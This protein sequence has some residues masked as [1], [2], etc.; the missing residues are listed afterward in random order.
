M[1][2]FASVLLLQA[3]TAQVAAPTT[4]EDVL[5][6]DT[7]AKL[8][9]IAVIFHEK[10]GIVNEAI[11]AAYNKHITKLQ[12]VIAFAKNYL[13]DRA[14]NFKCEDVLS[15][16]NCAKLIEVAEKFN[17]SLSEVTRDIE[18][19]IV[20]GITQGKALYQKTVELILNHLQNLSCEQLVDADTCQ[21]IKDFGLKVHASAQDIHRAIIDA[22][23][24]GLVQASDFLKDA[25]EYLKNDISCETVLSPDTCTKL[26]SLA[27][28]FGASWDKIVAVL[29]ESFANGIS[30]V[31]DLYKAAVKYI[32]DN[33]FGRVMLKRSIIDIVE[34]SKGMKELVEAYDEM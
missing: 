15:E 10:V 21:K 3:V 4:C 12:D 5:P 16:D 18:E 33:W 24:K 8:R 2:I 26:H 14:Q 31:S 9:N 32:M 25:I 30:K 23:S 19:A 7:C 28:K 13:M 27:D 17:V 34:V 6:A 22:Y 1:V 11:V 29:R 20:D